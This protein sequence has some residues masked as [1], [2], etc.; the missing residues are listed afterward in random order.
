MLNLNAKICMQ[1]SKLAFWD[2]YLINFFLASMP[3]IYKRIINNL[4]MRNILTLQEIVYAFYTKKI[5]LTNLEVIKKEN[6]HFAA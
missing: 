1:N 3:I 6:A 4:N 5:K 2:K